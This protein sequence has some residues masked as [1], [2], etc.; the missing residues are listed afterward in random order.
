MST[1]LQARVDELEEELSRTRKEF[2][3]FAYAAS[4][5]LRGPLHILTGFTSLLTRRYENQLDEQGVE[6]LGF[7]SGAVETLESLI[8]ALLEWSR[9][10]TKGSE[11]ESVPLHEI[12]EA[13][14]EGV[15]TLCVDNGATLRWPDY[16][17]EITGD[18][19]Q[20]VN[21]ISHLVRNG[22]LFT[23][24]EPASVAVSIDRE[25]DLWKIAVADR[26]IGIAESDI[27]RCFGVFQRLHAADEYPGVGMGLAVC[28]KIVHRHGGS[29]EVQ[30]APGE[31][32][33][34]IVALP[35][36]PPF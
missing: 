22:L 17:G 18:R 31:G 7:I 8:A 16:D 26:G 36:S 9:V 35:L 14:L 15:G 13:V 1:E 33:T 10:D 25:G 30:S 3:E 5:D 32:S 27:E 4:H 12:R 2:R 19:S 29:I 20:L 11:S 23:S 6:F 24:D 34:F 28:R 21:L